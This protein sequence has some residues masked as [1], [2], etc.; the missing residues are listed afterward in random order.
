MNIPT[1]LNQLGMATTHPEFTT[2]LMAPASHAQFK[3][4]ENPFKLQLQFVE[5]WKEEASSYCSFSHIIWKNKLM[6]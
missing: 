4:K 2:S 1:S 6:E 3:E 5:W